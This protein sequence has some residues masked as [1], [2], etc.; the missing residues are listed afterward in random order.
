MNDKK[1][2]I[3]LDV[4]Y[5]PQ[6]RTN[7]DTRRLMLRVIIALLPAVG[8]AVWQFGL[9]PLVVIASSVL[10]AVTRAKLRPLRSVTGVTVVS[11][12]PRPPSIMPFSPRITVS[13]ETG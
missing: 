10:S 2:R 1:E 11:L 13:S 7:V 4:A 3:I 5:Q 6:V 12:L 8:V 9:N